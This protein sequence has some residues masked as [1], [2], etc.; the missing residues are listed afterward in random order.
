MTVTYA[1]FPKYPASWEFR[2]EDVA[3]LNDEVRIYRYGY[4]KKIWDNLVGMEPKNLE[5]LKR[6]KPEVEAFLERGEPVMPDDRSMSQNQP[7]AE[8]APAIV[9]KKP[10][11]KFW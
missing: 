9:A 8:P 1:E 11:W 4:N 2:I 5:F 3:H 10:W 7:E 6:I